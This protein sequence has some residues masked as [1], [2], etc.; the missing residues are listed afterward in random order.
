MINGVLDLKICLTKLDFEDIKKGKVVDP[1]D[2][3]DWL[4][5]NVVGN[6]KIEFLARYREKEMTKNDCM[7]NM[8]FLDHN[9]CILEM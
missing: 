9:E 3:Y 1:D 7:A 6:I 8:E 4:K 2:S 5:R